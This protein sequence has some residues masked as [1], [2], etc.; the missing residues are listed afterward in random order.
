MTATPELIV[1][2]SV[3]IIGAIVYIWLS[4]ISWERRLSIL[5]SKRTILKPSRLR[6]VNR[7]IRYRVSML[8]F[9]IMAT[10][11][12]VFPILGYTIPYNGQAWILILVI[13]MIVAVA[14]LDLF[15]EFRS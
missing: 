2:L 12:G 7:Q 15:G 3:N 14:T 8:L 10:T 11:V 13:I 6:A 1:W 4:L 5:V 9:H